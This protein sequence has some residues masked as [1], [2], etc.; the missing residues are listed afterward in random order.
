MAERRSGTD[1]RRNRTE[2]QRRLRAIVERLADGILVVDGNGV[3]RFA[4][5][6]AELL[7]GRSADE[8]I[9]TELGFPVLSGERADIEVVRPGG[10]TVTAELRI[11]DAEFGEAGAAPGEKARL[12]S[13]RD[14]TD[15]RRAIERERQLERERAARAEA[16]AA[17]QAKSEFLAMMSHELRTPLNAVIGYAELL[18][19]GIAGPLTAEQRHQLSRIRTSG[20]HLLGLVNEVLDLAKI[21]SGRLSVNIGAGRA[22]DAADAALSLVQTRADEKGIRFVGQCMGDT[23]AVFDGDE[24]RVRQ[25]LVNLLSNAV[26]FTSPGGEVA[27]ECGTS[28]APDAEA[29]VQPHS[30]WVYLRVRDTGVGIPQAQLPFIFDPFVQGETGHT[31]S[32]DGSGLGLTIS[33]RLARLM[34]GDVTVRSVPERGS[35]FTLWLPG[36]A[37]D[38][39]HA[40]PAWGRAADEGPRVQGLGDIGELVLREV[41][42]I[43]EAVTVRLREHGEMPGA[44]TLK[45]S[46]LADHYPSFLADLG[47]MLIAIEEG[48]GQ[49]SGLIADGAEIQRILS[50]K[51][52]AQRAR[53]GW[54]PEHL[55]AEYGIVRDELA[56]TIRRRA[57]AIPDSAVDDALAI[58]T[59]VLEQAEE[60][61][62]RGF[63]RARAS[64]RIEGI[65]VSA[66]PA[67]V[68]G[69][70]MDAAPHG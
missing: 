1:R 57:R 46:Q 47:G 37:A 5:P 53:L 43:L 6:A 30:R 20:R 58:L 64:A 55:Q 33:R 70:D 29:R 26:K 34:G 21:E 67:A 22:G 49:P 13:L 19:L 31:R 50:E 40:R 9:G 45:F 69:E 41:E 60:S 59:R 66:T 8:L 62:L 36:G 17:S 42:T 28:A 25:I 18:D 44:K 10:E 3:I 24:D 16:E 27:I 54:S 56:R 39:L 14:V 11:V 63:H 61:S 38:E 65:G 68:A 12:V 32:N 7:F 15:R 35:V 2:E 4:N 51:H 48:G 52:G 23:D